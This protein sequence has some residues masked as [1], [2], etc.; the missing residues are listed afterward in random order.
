MARVGQQRYREFFFCC[1]HKQ[2]NAVLYNNY[3]LD[4]LIIIYS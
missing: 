2:I 4:A 1:I 3:Q